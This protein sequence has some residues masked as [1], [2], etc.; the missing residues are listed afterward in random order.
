M[1]TRRSWPAR[2]LTALVRLYQA[3]SFGR[4]P[5]CRYHPTCSEYMVEALG[6]HGALRGTG[7]GLRR[8]ARCGPWGGFGYDPVP[9][10]R[11]HRHDPVLAPSSPASGSTSLEQPAIGA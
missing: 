8:I 6:E 3:A 11:P 7:L 1:T 2:V 10:R 4:L 5:R 9:E